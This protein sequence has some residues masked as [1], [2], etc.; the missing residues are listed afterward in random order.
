MKRI[1]EIAIVTAAW[2][3][4]LI[5]AWPHLTRAFPKLKGAAY[6]ETGEIAGA[7]LP[8]DKEIEAIYMHPQ[9][10]MPGLNLRRDDPRI[11]RMLRA[12]GAAREVRVRHREKVSVVIYEP[13]IVRLKDGKTI[14]VNLAED[15][16]FFKGFEVR[17]DS[18]RFV[19]STGEL[20][21]TLGEVIPAAKPF[22]PGGDH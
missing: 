22:L 3:V 15:H 20:A 21:R 13:I 1:S 9:G 17:I 5:V 7:Y 11:S 19:D 2:L 12:I 16:T 14:E 10:A 4:V 8:E 6:V 18:A